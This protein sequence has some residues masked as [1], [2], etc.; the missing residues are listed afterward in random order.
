MSVANVTKPTPTGQTPAPAVRVVT[1]ASLACPKRPRKAS[2]RCVSR[3]PYGRRTG[4]VVGV[5]PDGDDTVVA[6]PLP[7]HSPR[8]TPVNRGHT[9]HTIRAG[10]RLPPSAAGFVQRHR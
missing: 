1:A 2:V 6:L 7:C 9:R 3:S 4:V 8:S 10:Q 5:G